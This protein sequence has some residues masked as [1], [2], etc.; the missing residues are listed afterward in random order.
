M[1]DAK[2]RTVE[3]TGVPFSGDGDDFHFVVDAAT[4]ERVTGREPEPDEKI[5]S[6]KRKLYPRHWAA[7]MRSKRRVTVKLSVQ[8]E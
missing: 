6:G 5:A 2:P 4:F 3:F 1:T 8:P 7:G